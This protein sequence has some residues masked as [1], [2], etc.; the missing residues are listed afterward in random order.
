MRDTDFIRR[1]FIAVAIA[2]L[3]AGRRRH[4]VQLA[5]LNYPHLRHEEIFDSVETFYRRFYLRVPKIVSEM[6]RRP[7]MTQRRLREGIEFFHFLR[8][9]RR[10]AH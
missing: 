5:P 6:A 3:A 10:V 2:A 8:D 4:G 1:I 7:Q 9:R